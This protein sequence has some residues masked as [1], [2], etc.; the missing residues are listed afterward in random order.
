MHYEIQPGKTYHFVVIGVDWFDK[1]NIIK[2]KE[3]S[4]G[5]QN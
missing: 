4:D 3:K 1:R 5:S 2:F